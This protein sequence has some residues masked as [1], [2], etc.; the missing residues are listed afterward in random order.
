MNWI[1]VVLLSNLS[2]TQHYRVFES[3]CLAVYYLGVDS[4]KRRKEGRK[5]GKIYREREKEGEEDRESIVM[6][7]QVI[8][9]ILFLQSV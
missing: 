4:G 8:L 1:W 9:F 2:D 7:L 3:V 5:E 6:F